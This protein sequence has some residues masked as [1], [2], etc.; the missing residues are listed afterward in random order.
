[1]KDK[2]AVQINEL[3]AKVNEMSQL[4]DS[5][6]SLISAVQDFDAFAACKLSTNSV[7][8]LLK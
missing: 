3:D 6:L 5:M 7:T 1:M 4:N 8:R 2:A